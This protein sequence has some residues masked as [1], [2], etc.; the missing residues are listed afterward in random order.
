MTEDEDETAVA[1]RLQ[2]SLKA[3][4]RD[5]MLTEVSISNIQY[6]ILNRINDDDDDDE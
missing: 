4:E 1:T 3:D 2:R 5:A 6:R